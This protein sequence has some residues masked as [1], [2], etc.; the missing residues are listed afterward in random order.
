VSSFTAV[1]PFVPS[2][3]PSFVCT[4]AVNAASDATSNVY[5]V[6]PD[7][8]TTAFCTVNVTG[9]ARFAIVEPLAGVNGRGAVTEAVSD[10]SVVAAAVAVGDVGLL[11]PH[12]AA[13]KTTA[14]DT[15]RQG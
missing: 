2:A 15:T 11:L 12:A 3:T 1:C 9:C 14:I 7:L 5:V 13:T 6:P 10:A 8:V 4:L